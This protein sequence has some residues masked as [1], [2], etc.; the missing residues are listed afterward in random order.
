MSRSSSVPSK[1]LSRQVRGVDELRATLGV[2]WPAIKRAREAALRQRER[3]DEII[4]PFLNTDTS[5]VV[6]GS[7]GRLEV[8]SGSDVDWSLLADGQADPRHF[9]IA[10]KVAEAIAEAKFKDPGQ[11]ATFGGLIFSHNLIHHI[12]GDNDDNSNTTRRLL[13]LLESAPVGQRD[14]YDRTVNSVLSRYVIED[15][16]LAHAGNRNNVPRFLH[17]DIVRYW[18]TMAV[19]FAYKR[20]A[21]SGKGWALR[22]AK[23]RMS[24]KLIYVA[25]ILMCYSCALDPEISVLKPEPNDPTIALR[26]VEH[27][28]K[29]VDQTPLDIV[30]QIVG[31]FPELDDALR[32]V[33]CEYDRFIG[34]LDDQQ[35]REHLNQLAPEA[36]SGDATYG[37]I[38][39]ISDAFQEA[40][41]AIFIDNRGTQLAELTRTYGV[42]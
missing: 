20:R 28:K 19:D 3:L 30:A 33:F 16:G 23:L 10:A 40:L 22:T 29:F 17:N 34:I 26:I 4:Q 27:L 11:E 41:L 13:L 14:A 24:R 5:F 2:Q 8:T 25:G 6:F 12:G 35:K 37:E 39:Q 21:R 9:D 36:V 32:A 1:A 42:F 38:R 31:G 18:R 15:F 7:L